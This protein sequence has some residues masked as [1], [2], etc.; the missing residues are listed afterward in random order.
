MRGRLL[1]GRRTLGKRQ[2][3]KK[4]KKPRRRLPFS[5]IFTRCARCMLVV[6]ACGCKC[7]TVS[8]QSRRRS[9]HSYLGST[10]RGRTAV[11]QSDQ[12]AEWHKGQLVQLPYFYASYLPTKEWHWIPWYLLIT[13]QHCTYYVV[14]VSHPIGQEISTQ[15]YPSFLLPPTYP[16]PC[17]LAHP[18]PTTL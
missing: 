15:V 8:I 10:V 5:S 3:G 14:G 1:V 4:E 7:V 11:R 2:E 16:L 6:C 18:L 17:T 13:M 12:F 9:I